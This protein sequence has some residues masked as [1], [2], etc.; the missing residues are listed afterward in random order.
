MKRLPLLLCTFFAVIATAAEPPRA[1]SESGPTRPA[2]K[3]PPDPRIAALVLPRVNFREADFASSLEYFRRKAEQQSN[4][5]LKLTFKRDVPEDFRPQHELSLDLT[6]VPFMVALNYFGE[7]AGVHFTIDGA[8]ITAKAGAAPRPQYAPLGQEAPS[9]V[10]GSGALVKPAAPAS[11]G[12]NT[13]RKTDGT[14]Q[15]DKSGF[16][17]HR[18]MGG[19]SIKQDPDNVKS[20]NCSAGTPCTPFCK[21][22]CQCTRPNAGSKPAK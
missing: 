5:A 3:Q 11:G 18:S 4:G 6:N 13:Y 1:P 22:L 17:P 20:V 7:L 12:K 9:S 15:P 21:C 16:I 19:W 14:I 8:A 2:A 10:Q